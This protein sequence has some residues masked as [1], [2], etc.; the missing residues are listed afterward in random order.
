MS[1][2]PGR[3]YWSG[4]LMRLWGDRGI[5][6]QRSAIAL[7]QVF[8]L[9]A[10]LLL[11]ASSSREKPPLYLVL[12]AAILLAWMIPRH[13][14]F[15][16]SLSIFLIGALAY[17]AAAP[18]T[19]RYFFAG[20]CVG[21]VA[22]FGRNHGVYGVFSSL[23]II[24]SLKIG[25][26]ATKGTVRELKYWVLGI[27][28]GYSPL[29]LLVV[30]KPGFASEFLR[31]IQYIFEVKATNLAIPIPWPWTVELG[32]ADPSVIARRL[33]VGV[34]FL[35]LGV[36]AVI[37]VGWLLWRSYRGRSTPPV[38][39]ACAALSLPYVHYAY[40]R[41]D[42]SHLAQGIFPVLVGTLALLPSRSSRL[43]W[44]AGGLLLAFSVWVTLP[45]QPGWQCA[46]M[47]DCRSIDV[48]GDNIAV[49]PRVADDVALIGK[50]VGKYAPNGRSFVVTPLWPAAYAL[51][52]RASPMRLIYTIFP[53]SPEFQAREIERIKQADPGFVLIVDY[54]LDGRDDLRFVNT[55]ADIAR[56][57]DS[58]Y[59][60]VTDATSN[61]AYWVFAGRKRK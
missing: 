5:L 20:A 33:L 50:L 7:F 49:V 35:A 30:I 12:S 27:L 57:I 18:T 40:S 59:A 28:I 60:R 55:H 9:F 44:S 34:S 58:T 19:R 43:Q 21:L 6:A 16:I 14:L 39:A 25:N 51:H 8:G 32:S 42:V 61:P 41:A 23:L 24:L 29:L 11:I 37:A 17:L 31:S 46:V 13:K 10:A 38:L 47:N 36:C 26:R 48:A 4:A 2:D 1:Y 45:H 52:E 22:V 54:A 56:F 53:R 15:D 3:Y